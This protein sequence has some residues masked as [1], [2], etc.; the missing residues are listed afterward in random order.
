LAPGLAKGEDAAPADTFLHQYAATFRF[1]LGRPTSIQVTPI[2]DAVLYL[3]SGPRTFV[4]D[5]YSFD[6][7]TKKERV[8][9]TA[10]QILG[11]EQEQ[12]STADKARR[13]RMRLPARGIASYQISRDGRLVLVPLSGRLFVCERESGTVRELESAAGGLDPRLSFDGNQVAFVREGDLWVTNV[14]GGPARRLTEHDNPDISWGDAEF[15]AQEEMGRFHGFWWSPNGTRIACQRTDVRGVEKFHIADPA[16]PEHPPESWAYPR[17]GK[18]NADVRLFLFPTDRGKAIE[19]EWN[20]EKYPYL[21]TVVWEEHAPLTLLVQNREQTEEQLLAVEE[22]T[23]AIRALLTEQD[24]AWLNLDEEMPR[25]LEDGSAFLWTSEREGDLRLEL[26]APDGK[27]LHALTPLGF[28]YRGVSEVDAARDCVWVRADSD[29]TQVNLWRIPLRAEGVPFERMTQDEPGL[30]GAVFSRGHELWVHTWDGPGGERLQ[31]VRYRAGTT[32]GNLPSK[33]ESPAFLPQVE[34]TTVGD[35]LQFHAAI[36]RPRTFDPKRRY[37]VLVDVYGGPSVQMVQASAYRYLLDQWFADRG[38]VVVLLDGRGT[39]NRGREWE[40]AL[41]GS[42]IDVPL[43]DQ[44]AGLKAL[45]AKFPELDL[46]RT[47]IFGWSYGGYMSALALMRRPDIFKAA[48]A[49]APVSDWLD[50][51]TH[52]TERYIGLPGEHAEAY[53]RSSILTSAKLLE[54]PLLIIHGTDDDNV[55]FTHSIQLCDALQRAGK[56]FEFLP[57]TGF[58]HMV[59]DPLITERLEERIAGFF[60][61]ELGGPSEPRAKKIQARGERTGR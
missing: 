4:Q 50:Y 13:E 48:V 20:H 53:E 26:H 30:H 7:R 22:K 1:R 8:L 19:V 40:R 61:R 32:V 16:H 37:P 43:A 47:G 3:R 33:A 14:T 51:D 24:P 27:L 25:W 42:F 59:T 39:P 35:T 21:C 15:V 46:E 9:F 60:I 6:P 58:T 5:L 17:P 12:L 54:R 38:F 11:G 29:P 34:F 36:V 23:G 10:E 18:A 45:G 31:T 55:Y 28:G 57:L 52:Y 56:P 49:G 41:R 2:G 44:V